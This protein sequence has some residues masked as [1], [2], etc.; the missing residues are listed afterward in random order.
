MKKLLYI[1]LLTFALF[2][3]TALAEDSADEISSAYS[4]ERDDAIV[5][6]NKKKQRRAELAQPE[7][8]E[9]VTILAPS[10]LTNPISLISRRYSIEKKLDMNSVFDTSTE[11]LR[12]IEE[13]D[14]ADI[15]IVSEPKLLDDMQKMGLIEGSSKVKIAG[16]RLSL[17][18]AKN[19]RIDTSQN[20]LEAMLDFIHNRALMAV[21]D[22]ENVTLGKRSAEMLQKIGKWEKFKKFIVQLPTSAKT[23]DYIIKSQTAGIVYASDAFLYRDNLQYIGDIPQKLHSPVEYYAAVVLGNNMPEAREFLH[24]LTAKEA[25]AILQ[26][27]KFVIE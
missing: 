5:E 18:A 17:V 7:N 12:K 13:G 3:N 15:V 24:Y 9:S 16:N 1:T 6:D 21:A 23:V 14:P 22:V 8:I 25:Q 26:K 11:L 19:F 27:A 4:Y 10:S 20:N 2:T